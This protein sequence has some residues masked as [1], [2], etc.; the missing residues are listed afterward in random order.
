[1]LRH[2][3]ELGGDAAAELLA[4]RADEALQGLLRRRLGRAL[5][6]LARCAEHDDPT[7][8]LQR[9]GPRVEEIVQVAQRCE[10]GRVVDES[11]QHVRVG[12]HHTGC[13][14]AEPGRP[15]QPS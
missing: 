5:A 6:V 1:V 14:E 2:E 3:D 4:H 9:P 15:G 8:G 12:Q 7:A 10:P 13:G 11:R